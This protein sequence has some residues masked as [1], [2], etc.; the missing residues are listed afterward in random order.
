VGRTLSKRS[1]GQF[2]RRERDF[3]PT[4]AK[5]VTPLISWLAGI[6]TFAEPCAGDGDLVRHLESHGLTCCYQGDIATGHDALAVDSYGTIDAVITNPPWKRPILHR[7][8]RHFARIAPAWLFIDADWAHTRQ[9]TPCLAC[10]TN[11]LPIGRVKWIPGTKNS[12]LDN[13]AWY[14]FDARHTAGPLLHPYRSTSP[15]A[16]LD[17]SNRLPGV[18]P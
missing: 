9:A 16:Q 17:L 10:C 6:R 5:A 14:R 4:P 2:E 12:G 13:V 15:A 3:Y 7:M 1:S 8:I 11:I 18:Q